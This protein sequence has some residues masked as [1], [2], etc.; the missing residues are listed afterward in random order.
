MAK[1][2]EI[3][4]KINV[5]GKDIELTKKQAK[6]LG[7]DLDKT[8]TSAH[9]ADRRLKGAAQASSN[10]TK[11]FSKMAQGISGGLVPAYATLAANIFAI[12]AA[13]RFLSDAANYRILIEGQ[14][15]YATVTGSSLKLL[16]SRLQDATGGQLAF[17]EAAQSV[18]IAKAAGV[19]SDQLSR[20]GVVAKNAS[21][22]L[23]RDLTDSLNRLVRG[24]TKAEPELLDE[25]GIILRLEIAA[26]KYGAKIGK[27]AK[28]LNIFEK[29]Q[30]VVNEVLEQGES[31][32][33]EFNT[34]L[35]QFS[36]LAKTFDDLINKIKGG[37]T[38]VAEFI[39]GGL[40]KN[41]YALTGAFALLGTGI[42]R[43]VMPATGNPNLQKAAGAA[44]GRISGI[45]NEEGQ[46]R[47]D[48]LGTNKSQQNQFIRS[49]SANETKFSNVHK[50]M[51][52]EALKSL[53]IM[54]AYNTQLQMQS[55]GVISSIGLKVKA[56]FQMMQADA[57]KFFGFMQFAGLQL[58]RLVSFI[59][60][61]GLVI[62]IGGVLAQY[63]DKLKDPAVVEFEKN[64]RKT[65]ES[66]QEQNKE[67]KALNKNLKHTETLLAKVN[68]LANFYANFSFAGGA[69]AFGGMEQ[70]TLRSS[71]DLTKRVLGDGQY[72]VLKETILALELQL[73]RLKEGSRFYDDVTARIKIFSDAQRESNSVLGISG[74]TIMDVGEA[75][76]DLG[77][78]GT[79]A[80]QELGD[81]TTTTQI[82][83]NAT[84]EFGK[85]LAKMKAPT[86]GLSTITRSIKDYGESL[87]GLSKLDLQAFKDMDKSFDLVV[88]EATGQNLA[89]FIGK[90]KYASIMSKRKSTGIAGGT[91]DPVFGHVGGV[92]TFDPEMDQKVM[93]LLGQAA[94]DRA[95]ELHDVEMKM[96]AN[97]TNQQTA[98]NERLLGQSKLVAGQI[99]KEEKIKALK[100]TQFNIETLIA[101]K[102]LLGMQV[103]DAEAVK[104]QADLD[105]LDSK[106]AIAEKEANLLAQVEMQFRDSFEAG[107]ATAIQGLIE[108]TTNLKDAFL[109]MTKSILTSMAQ[110]LAQQAAIAIM[111][112][113]PFF[114][115]GGLGSREGGI[116]K[117]PGYRSFGGGGVA[118]GPDSGYA[119]TLHGTEAVVP[120]PNGRS[121][122]VEMSGGAGANNVSVNVNM[123]TGQSSSTG[124][125]EQA[126]ALGRAIST[127]V[128]TELEKQQRPGGA[129]SPY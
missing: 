104:L 123:T 22:A 42:L 47:F 29:S 69:D 19:T 107:M 90:D 103:G 18:A 88:D 120:L 64:T 76:K 67:L 13:F 26:E 58:S 105:L 68:Q 52:L 11:N 101:E 93:G 98:M 118:D 80:T 33:G 114:P 44:Q 3:K 71:K 45:L 112:S 55:A 70:T 99:K 87:T 92:E 62:S 40:S 23:G 5:D 110:I 82:L 57:G 10:T 113:I 81:Y 59:G 73:S 1:K 100:V 97:K 119:A 89:Q 25:L 48:N 94:L 34:G 74:R 21:I 125:G 79:I 85:A 37:L 126:Y 2:D 49:M 111:G 63:M 8:G 83:T 96:I 12:G 121:I 65:V 31:K 61:A 30:A 124:D 15:E 75:L 116:L 36:I 117:S 43:A 20:I 106:L 109:N 53:N 38:G 6:Q 24:V 115:G 51:R 66:L 86:T 77:I 17:A 50:N 95:K 128:Q 102:K 60:Y 46:K 84:Q 56:E 39:A 27:T 108:G 4:I 129:L 91:P 7:K 127:A 35:N 32:F 41:I 78:N 122:P 16:T 72:D 9:S 14:R 28:Q 54:K